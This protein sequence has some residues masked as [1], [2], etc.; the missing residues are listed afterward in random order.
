MT[1]TEA[2][3]FLFG[4]LRV[5]RRPGKS[6]DLRIYRIVTCIAQ[7]ALVLFDSLPFLLGFLPVTL[8]GFF[9]IGRVAG[10]RAAL[11]WV[12]VTSLF[13]YGW[14]DSRFVPLLAGSILVNYALGRR[15]AG[16]AP[17]R[18]RSARHWFLAGVALNLALLGW[19]K[20]VGFL[21]GIAAAL[22]GRPAPLLQVA[23]PLAISFF[24]FQQIMFLADSMNRPGAG[25][26]GLLPYAACVSFFPHLIAGPIVR[27]SEIV[28]QLTAPGLAVARSEA[29]ADGLMIVLLGL[30]K[31][32]VLADTFAQFSD[33]GFAAA[34]HGVKLTFFEAWCAAAAYAL[35]IYFDFSGYS[36][37]AIGLA[38]M[39][40]VR[41]PLNFRSPYQSCDI[42]D[43]WRRW[44]ITLGLFLR[45]FVY[46]PLGGNR[47]GELRRCVNLLATML[48]GGLW[49]GAAWSFVLWGGLHGLF[50]VLHAAWQRLGKPLPV[51]VARA[52]TLLVVVVA[53]VPFRADGLPAAWI[54]LRGM[55]GLNGIALPQMI[56]EWMPW[57]G[58]I[59]RPV[60]ALP[61]LA[62]GRTLSLPEALLCL[63]LGWAIVL[64]VPHLHALT[65]RARGFA[66]TAGFAFTVQA[67]VFAPAAVPFVYFRF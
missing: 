52:L 13:F 19:C 60:A 54:V 21:A 14:W 4:I 6:L 24:T 66:L 28:P 1:A 61:N 29:L 31:K 39:M 44:H 36:D 33:P 48:L 46:I 27:P 47:R 38:R 34:A 5:T 40:N 3:S 20:Y 10:D 41:F 49:H 57:L 55:A 11:L 37:I 2:R 16:L 17:V 7:H 8:G 45:D 30:A 58:F 51:I 43:F 63:G 42:S 12:V 56:L 53:W 9:A 50:L 35:Q 26:T 65:S 67:L 64:L 23:L 15:I 59:A 25:R 32:V 18:P 62:D 22:V